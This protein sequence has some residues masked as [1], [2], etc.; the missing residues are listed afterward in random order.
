MTRASDTARLLAGGAVINED[1][2]DVDF[3]VESNGQANMLFVDGGNDT[4]SF[5]PNS[6]SLTIKAGSDDATNN[7]R[8]EGG[9]TT[10]TYLE[11]RGYLGHQFYVDTTERMRLTSTT[12]QIANE[13]RVSR[14][15]TQVTSMHYT[16]SNSL[17]IEDATASVFSTATSAVLSVGMMVGNRSINAVGT[18][19]ASG[20]D[21]A[22]Y[23]NNG[24]LKIS[25]G[26]IVGFDDKG[27]LTLTFA[28]AVRFGVKSTDP[29]YVGGDTW[30]DEEP[31]EKKTPEGE[32]TPEWDSWYERT[33][34]KR[35]LVDRIAYSG[36]VPVNVT[37]AKSGDYIIAVASDDGSID[38]QAIS[39]PDF[40][41]YKLAVGRVN[42]ILDDGRAEIA[43]IIH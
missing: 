2:N 30:A 22:E 39:N 3:R 28:D 29:A 1:S 40:E 38:G 43:V 21:Y 37:G 5:Q 33:E 17:G 13:L 12:A 20:A 16:F 27:I 36:K 15:G 42:K 31:P 6:G 4:V 23:E 11:Y 32:T 26:S 8:L 9:G 34:A 25:K 18:V 14:G 41:Q 7:V 10:S 19:N 24:G 35:A